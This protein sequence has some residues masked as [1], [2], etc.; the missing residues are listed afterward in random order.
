MMQNNT[1]WRGRILLAIM[2]VLIV[3]DQWIKIYIKTHFYLG[4][5]VEIFSWFHLHFVQNNGMAFGLELT[6]KYILT[7]ARII[8]VGFL[9]W[10]LWRICRVARI[11][12]GYC[13]CIALVC[14]GALG[15]IIDCVLYGEIFTNPY[16][17]VVAQFT[18]LG[19]GYGTWFQ[20]LVVDMFYFPLFSFTW[21]QWL[22]VIGG[23]IFS[24]FDP[25]FNLADAAITT[26]MIAIILFYRNYIGP[27]KDYENVD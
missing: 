19:H 5:D 13:L 8:L 11:A 26:G 21:P 22:P 9:G 17:P 12:A 10:Y 4:E 27:I 7:F 18:A 6:S 24:F 1:A 15:N 3:L 16:P 2:I 23:K 25:V 14:A 20:G